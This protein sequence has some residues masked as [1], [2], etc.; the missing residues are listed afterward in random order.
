MTIVART[1][2]HRIFAIDFFREKYTVAVERQESVLTLYECLE[3]VSV[4]Y[5]DRGAVIS[6]TPCDPETVADTGH[7]WIIFIVTLFVSFEMNRLMLDVPVHPVR[8]TSGKYIH[9]HRTV[10]ATEH[11]GITFTERHDGTVKYT[12]GGRYGIAVDDRIVAL[13][14]HDFV[15]AGR[16]VLPR[17]KIVLF[18][19]K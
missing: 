19:C 4:S 8:A 9:L 1:A 3:V 6:V 16:T 2:Q 18:H 5:A 15:A 14:P 7:A 17:E 10:V 13:A 12:V 11:P